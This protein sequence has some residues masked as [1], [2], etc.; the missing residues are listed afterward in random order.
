MGRCSSQILA[1]GALERTIRVPAGPGNVGKVYAVAISPDGALIAAG[2]WTRFTEADKREQIYLFDRTSGGL[3]RRIEGLPEVVNH[4]A[5]S[6]DEP[7][8]AAALARGGVRVY[9][10]Q[11]GWAQAARDEDYG[12]QSYGTDFAPDGQLAT[13]AH[14][15]K[16]RLYAGDLRGRIRPALVIQAPGGDRPYGIAFSPDGARL[17][18]GYD[19]TTNI[20]RL[21]GHT[22]APLPAATPLRRRQRYFGQGRLVAG[23]R[24][25]VR[26]GS[27]YPDQS[28]QGARLGR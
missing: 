10:K 4:L 6:P 15:S 24:D 1:D 14:D 20:D 8:L 18:V 3:V 19:D 13:T 9:T 11:T 22:L 25:P 17:A 7:S 28:S 27:L 21:D 26:G 5:F 2:G 23:R 16:I 12:D